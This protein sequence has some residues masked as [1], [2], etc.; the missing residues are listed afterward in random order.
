MEHLNMCPHIHD[1]GCVHVCVCVF[2]RVC[3][4]ML[5]NRPPWKVLILN[6]AVLCVALT[7]NDTNCEMLH[8]YLTIATVAITTTI[9][10]II[11]SNNTSHHHPHLISPPPSPSHRQ[12]IYNFLHR[13][14]TNIHPGR[15][16]FSE[17]ASHSAGH[18]ANVCLRKSTTH[19]RSPIQ[20]SSL[21]LPL[22]ATMCPLWS[23]YK[24]QN[25]NQMTIEN[26]TDY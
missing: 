11:S 26:E 7:M 22:S 14:H 2:E 5:T 25:R 3:K 1:G 10:A 13:L 19:S 6:V 12:Q 4:V 15:Q 16:L 8:N 17:S 20:S 24:I 9:T 18:V 23:T 21:P